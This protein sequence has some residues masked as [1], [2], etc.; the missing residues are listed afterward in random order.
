MHQAL[1]TIRAHGRP[2]TGDWTDVWTTVPTP[3]PP[4]PAFDADRALQLA[5]ETFDI[6]AGALL[7][8]K[9]RQ[10]T[11]FARAVEA[12]LGCR[13]RFVSTTAYVVASCIG[14]IGFMMRVLVS[15]S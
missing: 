12:M 14:I 1:P 2:I 4:P 9:A 6:E 7:G 13:G 15:R 5:R 3:P 8:L 10:G 11:D